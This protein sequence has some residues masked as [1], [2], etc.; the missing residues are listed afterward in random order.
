MALTA[1]EAAA[2]AIIGNPYS[3][4]QAV[5][6]P[7]LIVGKLM[8]CYGISVESAIVPM[9]ISRL[10]FRKGGLAGNIQA[11]FDTEPMGIRMET[12][13]FFSE[14]VIINPNDVFAIQVICRAIAA[15]TPV[16]IHNFVYEASGTVI[17]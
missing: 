12:D 17:A 13:A 6:S 10:I 5:A 3:C 7:Q 1:K 14:P 9:P 4:F 8:V 16:H 15:A 2:L 11:Q